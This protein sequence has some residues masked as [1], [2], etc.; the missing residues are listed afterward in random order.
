MKF[1]NQVLATVGAAT[2]LASAT[3]GTLA[4]V[5]VT[6]AD[7]DVSI[8][9]TGT[10]TVTVSIAET[11]AFND[12]LYNVTTAQTS[13]GVL[14]VTTTDDRGTGLGWNVTIGAT[15]FVRQLHPT[16][17][18][19][20]TIDNLTLNAGIPTRSSGVGAIPTD[21][22]NQTPVTTTQSQL[23]DA[24]TDEGDG[25]FKLPLNG[26]LNIPA[27]TLV[28]TYKSTVTVDVNFAP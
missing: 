6:S 2:L 24:A 4:T 28:D 15:D 12:V 18:D 8:N 26:S 19:D 20:I 1:R 7:V 23:W 13:T 27:G 11:T 17:G 14:T 3:L 22:T 9:P 5:P 10:G 16:V 21:T 25:Q